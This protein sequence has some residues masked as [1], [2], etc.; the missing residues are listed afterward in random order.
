MHIHVNLII[1]CPF[2]QLGLNFVTS[3]LNPFNYLSIW[4]FNPCACWPSYLNSFN[5]FWIWCFN[6]Y[7][8]WSLVYLD[9]FTYFWICRAMCTHKTKQI[10]FCWIHVFK[11]TCGAKLDWDILDPLII[12]RSHTF[13]FGHTLCTHCFSNMAM[14][15]WQTIMHVRIGKHTTP[16]NNPLVPHLGFYQGTKRNHILIVYYPSLTNFILQNK[17]SQILN[18]LVELVSC[19]C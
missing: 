4:C 2:L 18:K 14:V 12:H 13:F 11:L 6:S 5:Y 9:S 8:C 19:S 7:V 17:I 10:R 1:L 15:F 3:Y 16:S